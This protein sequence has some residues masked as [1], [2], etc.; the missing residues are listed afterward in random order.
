MGKKTKRRSVT[1]LKKMFVF[2]FALL[3]NVAYSQ[4]TC[5]F[6]G[7]FN[8]DKSAE[9]LYVYEL[10]NTGK[11]EKITSFTGIANPSYLTISADGKFVYSC[12][13]SKTPGGGSVSS[14]EFNYAKKSLTLINTQPSKGENPVYVSL[15]KNGKWLV[16][17][18]YTEGSVTVYPLETNGRIDSA[19][20][21]I[22]FSEGSIDK[23]RQDRAHIHSTVFSPDFNYVFM[24]DLG[25]DKIRCYQFD[26][27]SKTPLMP[28]QQEFVATNPGSGPRH[29]TFHPNGE[30][31][32]CIEELSGTIESYNYEK[33]NL[34]KLQQIETHPDEIKSGFE[35][36][37][38]HIS[39][40]GK[41]LYASNRGQENNIAIFSITENGLLKKVG[42]QETGGRHPRIFAID[43]SG[44]FLIVANVFT[45]NLVVFKRNI[46]TGLLEKAGEETG[47]KQPSCVKIQVYP[48]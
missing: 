8:W 46:Q 39:P 43:P 13:E 36:S 29:F 23:I 45:G 42:Y 35:S 37:D 20:Q 15:H 27:L 7:S 40:D 10:D 31:A 26:P 34:K 17:G 24:P 33:G 41:F 1:L 11:L 16:D 14:F 6:V 48:N 38:I 25:A 22:H 19:V 3:L 30:F 9:G 28:T 2:P 44:K 47:I 32:Y 18:N 12:T 5:V 21:N 4:H